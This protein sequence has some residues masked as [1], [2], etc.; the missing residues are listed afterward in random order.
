M[1]FTE[2]RQQFFP[3][4]TDSGIRVEAV[5]R[6]A[7]FEVTGK[8]YEQVG[9]PLTSMGLIPFTPTPDALKPHFQ[10][11][12]EQFVFYDGDEP[13]GW[14]LGEQRQGDSFFMGWSGIIPSH[15][16]RGIYSAFLEQLKHYITS[17]GYER[18]TSNHMVNNRPIL[19]A[20]LKAGFIVSGYSLDERI[21]AAVWLTY[22]TDPKREQAFETAFSLEKRRFG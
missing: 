7:V 15:Q 8:L 19:I 14:S 17:I 22:F 21:G 9:Q 2:A 16:Q 5:G 13:V 10:Q 1:P 11:H 4:T 18:I 3:F 12:T 20:K 6:A